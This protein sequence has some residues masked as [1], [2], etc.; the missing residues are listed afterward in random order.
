MRQQLINYIRAGYPGVYVVSGEEARV[1]AELKSVADAIGYRLFAWSILDGLVDTSDGTTHSAMDPQEVLSDVADLPERSLVLLRDFHQFL[2]DPNPIITRML[3]NVMRVAKTEAKTLVVLGCRLM[4]PPELEREFV[5]MEFALP[6]RGELGVVLDNI[7]DSAG[8]EP[9]QDEER[10]LLLDAATGLT[11]IEAENAF[12]LSVVEADGLNAAIVAREKAAAVKKNGLLEIVK[13]PAT[14]EDIGGLDLLKG[15][16]TQRRGAF[17]RMAQ[18]Y[19]LPS[20][21]GLLI[22]G[23]PGTG[24]SLTAKATASVFQRPLVK[25]DAG[26]IYAGLVGQSEENLRS[27]IRTVE[28]IAPCVLW[29]DEI[30]KAFA[31]GRSSGATDGGT[32]SRVFGTFLTWLQDRTAP[33][34]VVATANDVTQLPPELLRKGRVDELMFVD[35]P[36]AEEREAIWRIQIANY[37]RNPGEFD[38]ARLVTA[39]EGLTG[40]EIEQAVID[41]LY[42]AFND[43]REPVDRNF[44]AALEEAVPLSRLM[45]DG[46]AALRQWAKGRTRPASSPG[47]KSQ[48]K[49]RITSD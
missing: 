45:G 11:S 26:R 15:W 39:S 27:V 42:D 31:G 44:L 1:E 12:A 22:I 10:D 20:P 48:R 3:K 49:R 30:E 38:L 32:S 19:G 40:S 28:A 24:K 21:K 35:L 46:I 29:I 33:V 7:A 14:L 17:G 25:L 47:P 8:R 2:D 6:N 36:N 37:A 13:T 41:G 16:L 43:Y 18:E 9:P 23:I 34:F 5:V 4:F